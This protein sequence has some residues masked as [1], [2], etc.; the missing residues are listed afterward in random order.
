MRIILRKSMLTRHIFQQEKILIMAQKNNF[1][2]NKLKFKNNKY[3]EFL[4]TQCKKNI[5][6]NFFFQLFVQLH[7]YYIYNILE[8]LLKKKLNK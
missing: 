1:L 2:K 6:K 3:L 7:Y 8:N 4:Q 5:L